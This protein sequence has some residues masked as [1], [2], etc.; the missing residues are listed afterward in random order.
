MGRVSDSG[1]GGLSG[2]VV[3]QRCSHR[4]MAAL[5]MHRKETAYDGPHIAAG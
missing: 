3:K 5:F 4:N 1:T 2:T